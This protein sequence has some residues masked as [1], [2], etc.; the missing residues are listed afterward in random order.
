MALGPGALRQVRGE[1]EFPLSVDGR[2]AT[3][4]RAA[5]KEQ[6]LGTVGKGTRNGG[7]G[8]RGLLL[9][10]VLGEADLGP[11]RGGGRG[12]GKGEEEGEE[13]AAHG[14]FCVRQACAKRVRGGGDDT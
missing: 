13:E 3:R 5:T 9:V 14:L 8:G 2:K 10:V 12:E 7:H 11:G 4:A 6:E 1:F